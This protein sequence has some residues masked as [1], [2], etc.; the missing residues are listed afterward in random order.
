MW[1][2]YKFIRWVRDF[3]V[4]INSCEF[5]NFCYIIGGQNVIYNNITY[6]KKEVKVEIKHVHCFYRLNRI[7]I[8]QSG[9]IKLLRK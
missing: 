3:W 7:K 5:L 6:M 2:N 1:N 4:L 9:T 8:C